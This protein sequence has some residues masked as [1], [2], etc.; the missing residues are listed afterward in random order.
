MC[1]PLHFIVTLFYIIR[2]ASVAL[3]LSVQNVQTLPMTVCH[4]C[5]AGVTHTIRCV[6]SISKT[7][8]WKG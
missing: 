7:Q 4:L 1:L 8:A 3:E 5:V 6:P 2:Q